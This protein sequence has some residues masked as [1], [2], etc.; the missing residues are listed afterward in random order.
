VSRLGYPV[1]RLERDADPDGEWI[2][3]GVRMKLDLVGRK[4]S[5]EQWGRLP[6]SVRDRLTGLRA[7]TDEEIR[8]FA[9]TLGTS[10]R[11]AGLAAEEV[12]ESKR[13]EVALWR[14]AGPVGDEVREFLDSMGV[15]DLWPRLDRFGRYLVHVFARKQDHERAGNALAELGF[16][17]R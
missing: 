9:E 16:L 14:D 5:L 3:Y 11:Q 10:L 2:S 6:Q 15:G 4:I 8:I 13:R 17:T 12:S 1:L 7:E